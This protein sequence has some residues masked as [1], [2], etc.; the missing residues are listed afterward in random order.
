[1]CFFTLVTAS[2]IAPVYPGYGFAGPVVHAA[3]FVHAPVVAHA[4]IIAKHIHEPVD[5]NP[6]YR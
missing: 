1:M 2:P 5:P 4:P 6:Q 3:P